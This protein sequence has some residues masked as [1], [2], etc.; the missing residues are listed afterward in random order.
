MSYTRL[1]APQAKALTRIL[2]I[3]L[4][5]GRPALRLD[6]TEALGYESDY[7]IR[8]LLDIGAI[9]KASP[10]NS[11]SVFYWPLMDLKGSPVHISVEI[12]EDACAE[13]TNG[14]G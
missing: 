13:E 11:K 3:A 6:V 10:K 2:Q 7:V 4:N 8:K 5:E 12:H 14:D 1:T 9:R